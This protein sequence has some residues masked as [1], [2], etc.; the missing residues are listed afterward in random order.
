MNLGTAVARSLKFYQALGFDRLP[1]NLPGTLASSSFDKAEALERLRQELGPCTRCKLSTHRTN[2][3]FGGP[4]GC[5]CY[6]T[7]ADT[8]CLE[9]FRAETPG[10]SWQ[11]FQR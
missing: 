7:V 5:T 10:R 4:D 8:G 1:L 3:A 2:I 11:L 6:V 9:R